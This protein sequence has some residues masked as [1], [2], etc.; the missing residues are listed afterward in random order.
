MSVANLAVLYRDTQQVNEALTL[1]QRQV[2][3]EENFFQRNFTGS[4]Q[5]RQAFFATFSSS[6][7]FT[8]SLHLDHAPD[9]EEALR[10]AFQTWLR[11]KGRVLDAQA[12]TLAALRRNL[13]DEG[14]ALLDTLRD[15]RQ[16][17]AHLIETSPEEDFDAYRKQLEDLAQE[18]QETEY[19]ISTRSKSFAA[20]SEPVTIEAILEHMPD[21]SGLLQY[22]VYTPE[23]KDEE[24]LPPHLAAYLLHADGRISGVKLGPMSDF[25]ARLSA[26]RQ[27]RADSLSQWLHSQIIAPVLEDPGE[28]THLFISPDGPLNLTPFDA[29]QDEA[30]T[31]L[32]ETVN[33][34]YLST[35]RDLL[36]LDLYEDIETAA[37]VVVADPDYG[38]GEEWDPLPNTGTE[39]EALSA[40]F[41][42]ATV[43]HG[44]AATVEALRTLDSPEFLHIA[45]HG[46]A[47]PDDE[48]T[49]ADDNPM[50]RAGLV[51]SGANDPS[52]TD[53]RLLASEAVT[54][55][56]DGTRLVVLSACESGLGQ[57]ENGEGVY[58]MRRAL[59][60]AGAESQVVSLWKVSDEATAAFMEGFYGRVKAGEPLAEALQETKLQMR[61]GEW[62]DPVFWA[63]FVLAGDWR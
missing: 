6:T 41:P 62:S 42:E 28:L 3:G 4:E 14:Q 37:P 12:D 22:A 58:G 44:E 30:G 54:L 60:L 20:Q 24:E 15:L 46:F 27:T 17:E 25:E 32:L 10:L 34:S 53:T 5:A 52:R 33:I 40:L 57:A 26:F 18:V 59:T 47:L 31:P 36:R 21:G 8:L 51:F 7:H 9:N 23:N 1:T 49:L 2:E 39:A 29:L 63:P 43:H 19:A 16:R 38:A 35:G 13:D 45:T 50:T 48:G 11:R 55:D 56:L 61:A